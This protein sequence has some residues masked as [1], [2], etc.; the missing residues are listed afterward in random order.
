MNDL[1][2]APRPTVLQ[3]LVRRRLHS[4]AGKSPDEPLGPEDWSAFYRHHTSTRGAV[5]LLSAMPHGPR[6]KICGAPFAG[7]G[8][9]VL[10]PLGYRPS[11]KNPYFCATCIEFAPPG[12]MEMEVGVMF[13]DVRGFTRLAASTGSESLSALL[14]RFYA[15]AEQVLFPEALVDKLIGDCVMALYVPMLGDLGDPRRMMYDHA[16]RLLSGVGYGTEEGPFVEVGVGMD[17]G[18]AFVGNIGHRWLWDFTA[19]GQVVN[20]AAALQAHARGGEIVM[21]DRVAAGND[22]VSGEPAALSAKGG[23]AV[24]AWRTTSTV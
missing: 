18:A 21:T 15:E 3:R 17:F 11:R 5:K 2:P 24:R 22:A 10:A 13:A 6:C 16:R 14:R 19:V 20:T 12:G 8:S 7:V 1:A 4:L 23:P 9:R